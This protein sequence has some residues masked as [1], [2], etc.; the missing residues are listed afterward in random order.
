MVFS[1]DVHNGV[2]YART[3]A[4]RDRIPEDR[5]LFFYDSGNDCANFAS[6][7][8]W[9]A[10]GGWIPGTDPETVSINRTRIK[11]HVRM[12]P[13]IWYGSPSFPGSEKWCRVVE[14]FGY[15]VASGNGPH[16]QMIAEGDWKGVKPSIIKAGDLIQVVVKSYIPGRYGH[17]LYVT[18]SGRTWD[19]ILIC[20]HSFDRLD[21]P[22][23]SFA[24][25]PDEYAKFRVLRFGKGSFYK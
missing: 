25:Y 17:S 12:A 7:C 19:D 24:Q 14:F 23:S 22:L 10:Y 6:Q 18:Q 8:I 1:Y 3:Y 21:E 15:V 13:Y 11:S 4:L 2:E 20:C 16:A 9:A 5:R